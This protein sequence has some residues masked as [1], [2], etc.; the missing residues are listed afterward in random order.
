MS[1]T[2]T[3]HTLS[4]KIVVNSSLASAIYWNR[5]LYDLRSVERSAGCLEV[6]SVFFDK[7]RF[8]SV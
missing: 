4:N 1:Y 6:F 8:L 5:Y 7:L 2:L 3:K